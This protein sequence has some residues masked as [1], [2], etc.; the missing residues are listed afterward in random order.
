METFLE[1]LKYVIPTIVA[2]GGMYIMLSAFFDR[3]EKARSFEL[4]KNNLQDNKKI[5]LPLRLQAYE[6]L[7]VFLERIHPNS[8]LHRVRQ[9]NMSAQD[10]QLALV[11]NVREEYEFNVSQQLYVSKEAWAMVKTVK[12]EMVKLF[13]LIGSKLPEGA[14]SM[15]YSRALLDY[16]IQNNEEAPTDVAIN[17]LKQDVTHLF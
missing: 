17:Y 10:L 9:P 15:D 2:L 7:I 6:R 16:L 5:S 3:E 12:D 4:R 13:N 1:I 11:R 14:N 8:I